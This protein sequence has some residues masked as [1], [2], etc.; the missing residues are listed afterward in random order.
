MVLLV[1][2]STSLLVPA[3]L[4]S[5]FY[6]PAKDFVSW[7]IA[8]EETYTKT[9]VSDPEGPLGA[10]PSGETSEDVSKSSNSGLEIGACLADPFASDSVVACDVEHRGEVISMTN[11]EC[12]RAAA[13]VYAGGDP[14]TD[15]LSDVVQ[16]SVVDGQCVVALEGV[17]AA[18]SI[19]D[20]LGTDQ[21]DGLRECFDRQSDRFVPCAEDHTGEVVQRMPAGSSERLNCDA[22]AGRYMGQGLSQRF[23][24]LEVEEISTDAA[25][26]CVV[27]LRSDSSWL[28]S[29][30]RNLGNA[31]IQTSPM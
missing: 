9:D 1:V 8:D 17:T 16:V 12:S 27:G 4:S 18:A 5:G 26:R 6:P 10:E 13:V 7:L 21:G 19:E 29:S 2:V 28:Q 31:E 22:A 14:D 25:R 24:D 11:G 3:Q 20:S 15:L 23:S 30:L